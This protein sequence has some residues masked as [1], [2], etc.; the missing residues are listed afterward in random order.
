MLSN[1]SDAI[2]LWKDPKFW[3]DNYADEEVL[4]IIKSERVPS[5]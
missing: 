2:R 1:D 5:R 4:C 3:L